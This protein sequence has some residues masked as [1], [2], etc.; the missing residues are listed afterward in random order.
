MDRK[1]RQLPHGVGICGLTVALAREIESST[2][3][4]ILPG[5]FEIHEW[6][7]MREFCDSVD[8]GEHRDQLLEAIHGSEAFRFFHSTLNRL[9]L[10]NISQKSFRVHGACR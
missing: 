10:N 3:F 8:N 7:I 5:K 4:A 9:G 2:H 6:S 1:N